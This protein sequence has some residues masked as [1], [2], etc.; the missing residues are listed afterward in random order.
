MKV[1]ITAFEPFGGEIINPALEAMNLLPD[2]IGG[3]QVIKLQIPTVFN[4]SIHTVWQAMDFYKPNAVISLGQAGGR[5][6]ISVERIAVNIDD[7]SIGDNEGNQPVDR[8][9]LDDGENA[10][11]ST[12]PIKDIV[13][14]IRQY[15]IPA[16]ISNTAGTF[17]CNHVMYGVLYRIH[18]YNMDIKA[19]FIHVPYIPEQVAD[20]PGKPSMPLDNIVKAITA[21]CR[22]MEEESDG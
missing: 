17:V 14:A 8:P 20:K 10:Y 2:S 5:S 6:C 7:A 21:A 19:G 18:K 9:V 12:L 11:F 4:K 16:E 13:K 15:G 3:L 22:A 1:L